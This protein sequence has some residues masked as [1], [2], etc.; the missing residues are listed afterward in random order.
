MTPPNSPRILLLWDIDGTLITTGRS[1]IDAF[2]DGFAR[3]H[4]SR[5]NVSLVEFAGRTD[6]A[7]ARQMLEA[8]G[9]PAGECDV[10]DLLDA[11]LAELGGVMAGPERRGRALDGVVAIL[12]AAHARPDLAQGLLTG[13]LAHGAQLKLRHFDLHHYFEF[14]AFADDS[15]DRNQLPP[16]AR[17]RAEEHHGV[18]FPP[19]R[20]YVIGDTPHDVA[21]GKAI[22]AHTIAV[23]TGSFD[24]PALTAC[25]PTVVFPDLSDTRGFFAWLD[26]HASAPA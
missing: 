14:G 3:R 24:V 18:E 21:C 11:Y 25:E 6:R 20:I 1:G 5:P 9:L 4:G 17:R 2:A 13:N 16:H 12:A 23:A 22:G 7:I 19:E 10:M 15:P 26:A 8:H